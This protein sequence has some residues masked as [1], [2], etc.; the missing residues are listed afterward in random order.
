MARRIITWVGIALLA[1]G[2]MLTLRGLPVAGLVIAVIG[3]ATA[4]IA[5][6]V[7]HGADSGT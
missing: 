1:A 2:F 5:I 3:A 4:M 6:F 7:R